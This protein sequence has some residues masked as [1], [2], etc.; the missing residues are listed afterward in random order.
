[1]LAC[2]NTF[3]FF[4]SALDQLQ[5]TNSRKLRKNTFAVPL[6][7]SG[8]GGTYGQKGGYAGLDIMCLLYPV[9]A[10]VGR[11]RRIA[12]PTWLSSVEDVDMVAQCD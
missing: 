6:T 7:P 12:D 9:R 4:T 11:R 3:F 2:S 8:M 1:M 10:L 5:C